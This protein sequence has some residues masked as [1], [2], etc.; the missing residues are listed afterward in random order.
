[1]GRKEQSPPVYLFSVQG[2]FISITPCLASALISYARGGGEGR[3]RPLLPTMRRRSASAVA[4]AAIALVFVVMFRSTK[5]GV[6]HQRLRRHHDSA[7]VIGASFFGRKAVEGCTSRRR[8]RSTSQG[9][10][11]AITLSACCG[12]ATPLS[13]FRSAPTNCAAAGH[14]RKAL[15]DGSAVGAL[16]GADLNTERPRGTL[17]DREKRRLH[18]ERGVQGV[19][20][21]LGVVDPMKTRLGKSELEVCRVINGLCQV[22]EDLCWRLCRRCQQ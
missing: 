5:C 11:L 14:Q 22:C 21:G 18:Q 15:A 10:A 3:S 6:Q 19:D 9:Q 8:N 12:F 16:A 4:T 2:A 7:A 20:A 1:M 13:F 17:G